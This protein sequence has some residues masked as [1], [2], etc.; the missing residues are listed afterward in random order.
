MTHGPSD[1]IFALSSGR[2]P[3]AIAVVRVSGPRAGA[4][5]MALAGRMPAPRQAMLARL[6]DPA[7]GEV[8]RRGPG[9]VVS[10]RRAARPAR[11][12]PNSSFMAAAPWLRRVL[13]AL[14]GSK[15]CRPAE[16]G[17]FTRRAFENGKLDLT[18]VGGSRRPDRCRDRGAAAP[19]VPAAQGL[20][21]RP[22]RGVAD[23]A[24]R[25]AGAGGGADR[26]PRRGGCAAGSAAP[27]LDAARRTCARD[28]GSCSPTAAAA[29]GCGKGSWSPLRVRRMSAS[30]RLIN[31]LAR[32]AAAI[33]SPY[34]GTTR[35]VIEVHLDLGGYPVTV[36]DTA[37][38]AR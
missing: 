5:L 23:A 20:A 32:R 8:D 1:T 19:G 9:A 35:D 36:L 28:R 6:R 11:T 25:G 2:P 34:A 31:R 29:S 14:G 17:E 37:G 21:R 24:D 15:G 3:A 4:A 30:R 38:H 26:F 13:A 18:A 33:V 7:T 27:A 16:P 12:P 22:G 10:R